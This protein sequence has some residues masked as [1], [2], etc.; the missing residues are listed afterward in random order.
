MISEATVAKEPGHRGEQEISR[1]TIAQGMLECFGEPVVTNSLCFLLSHARLWVRWAP[2]IPCALLSGGQVQATTRA[3]S[4]RG[5][6]EV[7]LGS[8]F[9]N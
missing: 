3:E 4:R 7:R 6:A 8:L 9:E 5:N 1:K 2:G